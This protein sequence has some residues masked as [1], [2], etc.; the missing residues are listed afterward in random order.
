GLPF[1]PS[2]SCHFRVEATPDS[3]SLSFRCKQKVIQRFN[4]NE[5]VNDK[6]C[7]SKLVHGNPATPCVSHPACVT[8]PSSFQPPT[9]SPTS[10]TAACLRVQE[11]AEVVEEGAS[12]EATSRSRRKLTHSGPDRQT[13]SVSARRKSERATKAAASAGKAKGDR[14]AP[15]SPAKLQPAVSYA[16][17]VKAGAAGG[18][19]EDDRPAIG[20]LLQNQWG[21]SFISD[22]RPP[23]EGSAPLPPSDAEHP[24]A[25]LEPDTVL[26]VQP[27]DQTPAPVTT[28]SSIVTH[29]ETDEAN[30][31]LLLSCRHLVEALSYHSR[32]W[33]IICNRQKKDPKRV[34]WYKGTQEHPA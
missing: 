1:P 25:D 30:G 2:F 20:V 22:A 27:P 32:E 28:S 15:D 23:N 21:L 14:A 34:V 7:I 24:D 10:A 16:S 3:A 4:S 9:Q 19:L 33:N 6:T 12:L 8:K 11:T 13:T 5:A 26:R 29:T 17:K 31:E 18:A